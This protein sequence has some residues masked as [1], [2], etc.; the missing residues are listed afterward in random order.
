MFV[1]EEF[2]VF[3]ILRNFSS[4]TKWDPMLSFSLRNSNL[5]MQTAFHKVEFE[6][7]CV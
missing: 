6:S 3:V 1:V 2:V 5:S 7:S 4:L